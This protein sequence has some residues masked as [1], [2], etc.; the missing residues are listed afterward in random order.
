MDAFADI[1]DSRCWEK[2]CHD[3]DKARVNIS[4]SHLLLFASEGEV[5]SNTLDF[6]L[7]SNV[8]RSYPARFAET[9]VKELASLILRMAFLPTS[10]LS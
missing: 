4:N 10:H 3:W 9:C 2:V 8:G 7:S 1:V 5:G 6:L